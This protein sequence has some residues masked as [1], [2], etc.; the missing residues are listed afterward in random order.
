MLKNRSVPTKRA[1]DGAITPKFA[2]R[3]AKFGAIMFRSF[4]KSA[5]PVTQTVRRLSSNIVRM[6]FYMNKKGANILDV[7]VSILLLIATV[8]TIILQI[9]FSSPT[10]TKIETSLFSILQFVFSL[11][12][13]WVLARVS[14]RSEF[15]ESQKKFAISAYRKIIEI[16]N[17]VNR[18]ISRTTSHMGK[19]EN[20][21]DHELDVITEI[22]VGIRE[23]IRSSISDWADII[24]D[25]IETV[26]KIQ[27]IREKQSLED[28]HAT[29]PKTDTNQP[30]ESDAAVEKLISTLPKSLKIT[31]DDFRN[32]YMS[33][34][35]RGRMKL[36]REEKKK[37]Y[38]ELQGFYESSLDKD[39]CD[40]KGR[41]Y[42]ASKNWRRP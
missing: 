10:S 1:P 39:V 16:N 41:R 17:A 31:A 18:L 33:K 25:E 32:D 13:S 26:E 42:F 20:S 36:R 35:N 14:L 22:G 34:I 30:D 27:M 24:G 21:T 4:A 37:G 28:L 15:Q 40:F 2:A 23:S 8:A 7:V 19:V 12:F 6:E 38:V 9:L 5:P 11:A 3:F 29:S